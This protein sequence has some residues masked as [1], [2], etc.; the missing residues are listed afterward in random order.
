MAK[1]KLTPF[2]QALVTAVLEDYADIPPEDAVELEFS[3][4][5]EARYAS[6]MEKEV[7]KPV[8]HLGKTARRTILIAILLA[9]LASTVLAVPAV[10]EAIIK[11][12]VTESKDR[13]HINIDPEYAA[14]APKTIETMY[15]PTFIPEHYTHTHVEVGSD[16]VCY[17]YSVGDTN[18]YIFFYQYLIPEDL[19]FTRPRSPRDEVDIL[20]LNGLQIHNFH[21][22]R[23]REDFVWTDNEYM[24]MLSFDA[25]EEAVLFE[26]I[27]SSI[28]PA[29]TQ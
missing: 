19:S 24:Y 25:P 22:Y 26:K 23:F 13:Y 14:S 5:F 7:W 27:F 21:Y 2:Q 18:Q 28:Q 8:R 1:T 6:P 29:D 11:F 12:F 16:R 4:E 20:Y 9:L 10:Q 3:P 15:C 17:R